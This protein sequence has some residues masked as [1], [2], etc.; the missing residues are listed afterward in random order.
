MRLNSVSQFY[1]EALWDFCISVLYR[2]IMGLLDLS[3]IKMINGTSGSQFNKDDLWDFCIS[4]LYMSDS[5]QDFCISVL[6]RCIMGFL[7]H[8]FTQMYIFQ[9][10]PQLSLREE[11][12]YHWKSV[13]AFF[14]DNKGLLHCYN[15]ITVIKVIIANMVKQIQSML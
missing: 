8:S 1:T 6:Y 2:C 7:D 14:M 13:T 3:L 5:L 4:V 15:T 10:A 11:F 9:L 12:V